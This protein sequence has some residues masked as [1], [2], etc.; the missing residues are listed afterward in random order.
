MKPPDFQAMSAL[1]E[2]PLLCHSGAA[3]SEFFGDLKLDFKGDF[4]DLNGISINFNWS[5]MDFNWSSMDFN[6]ILMGANGIFIDLIICL[7][8]V[9]GQ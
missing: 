5:S 7:S 1:Q 4:M 3:C 6:G 8:L 9:V 2:G